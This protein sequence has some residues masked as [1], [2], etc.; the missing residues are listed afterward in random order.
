MSHRGAKSPQLYTF[1]LYLHLKD[2]A[3]IDFVIWM[4]KVTMKNTQQYMKINKDFL[5]RAI[6]LTMTS[7]SPLTQKKTRSL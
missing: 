4:K 2:D 7:N 6:F 3:S 5:R 1:N